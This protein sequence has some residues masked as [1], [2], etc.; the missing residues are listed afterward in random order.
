MPGLWLNVNAQATIA[1]TRHALIVTVNPEVG[2]A[3]HPADDRSRTVD[4][5][6]HG[7]KL[8]IPGVAKLDKNIQKNDDIAMMTLKEELVGF[9]KAEMSS[10][11][12]KETQKGIFIKTS[13]V[14]MT[15]G[16]YP[17]YKVIKDDK[18]DEKRMDDSQEK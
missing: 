5:I 16:T 12:A 2:D 13:K 18:S 6:C 10:T 11:E 8:S 7:A 9:G 17:K 14:L 15:T 3:T 1:R 4:S